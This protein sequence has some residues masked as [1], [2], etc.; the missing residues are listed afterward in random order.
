V[1]PAGSPVS[2]S[3]EGRRQVL[4]DVVRE[5]RPGDDRERA[6][7]A[8]MLTLLA[9]LP[10]PLDREAGPEHVT[11]SAVVVGSRG[12]LLHRHR[13]LGRWLQPGGH[14]EPGEWPAE[15]AL[16][17]TV[18]ETGV[19]VRHPAGRPHLVHVDVHPAGEHLHLD[20]RYL[21]LGADQDPAPAPGESPAVAWFDWPTARALADEALV[22]ALRA[23]EGLLAGLPEPDPGPLR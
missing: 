22:G 18:E 6:S 14:L 9:E 17:E 16:R 23:A 10:S 8:R 5:H 4:L 19:A 2:A 15:A 21:L 20:L 1:S 13:R 3:D 12:V 7:R 11:G